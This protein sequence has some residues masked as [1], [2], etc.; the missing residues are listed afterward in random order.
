M[1]VMPTRAHHHHSTAMPASPP[2]ADPQLQLYA[3]LAAFQAEASGVAKDAKNPHFRN[4]YATLAAVIAAVQPGTAHGLSHSQ[5][6]EQAADGATLL[7][8]TIHHA[9]GACIRSTLPIG[10]TADWQKN[11]SAITYARRYSLLAAYGLAPDDDDDGNSAAPA[12]TRAA[13]R[14]TNGNGARRDD[15]SIT[16]ASARKR[17]ME[18]GL[19]RE[20]GQALLAELAPAGATTIDALPDPILKRLATAGPSDADVARWNAAGMPEPAADADGEQDDP[21]LLW[22][23][24]EPAA[25]TA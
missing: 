20:G 14:P 8:T 13:A 4:T 7:V 25:A 2:A 10:F 15:R 19:T 11:G 18:A 6:F 22:Q 5:T 3:A 12:P 16:V 9:A 21:P 23:A 1:L 24:A 17:L